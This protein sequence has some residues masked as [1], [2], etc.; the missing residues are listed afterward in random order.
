MMEE[1]QQQEMEEID[2]D[3]QIY[4]VP[5]GLNDVEVYAELDRQDGAREQK[6]NDMNQASHDKLHTSSGNL[7][8]FSIDAAHQ[9]DVVDLLC[10]ELPKN[11]QDSHP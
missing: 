6:I 2:V 1:Q 3:G 11:E 8:T 5:A 9:H 4:R 10:Q 7:E